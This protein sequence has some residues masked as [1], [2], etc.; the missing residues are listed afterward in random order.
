[1]D[2]VRRQGRPLECMSCETGDF[3]ALSLGTVM[4]VE[5]VALGE[6]NVT[7][8]YGTPVRVIH[9]VAQCHPRSRAAVSIGRP[10]CCWH[11]CPTTTQ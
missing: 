11:A 4:G 7:L 1:M 8:T 5:E 10:R 6:L 2:L 9:A 3:G